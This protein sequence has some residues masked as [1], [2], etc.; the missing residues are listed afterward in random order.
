MGYGLNGIFSVP[1]M[2]P[3]ADT[4][5][6][7][8]D[9]GIWKISGSQ[10]PV[11]LYRES[12]T[13][14]V[15]AAVNVLVAGSRSGAFSEGYRSTNGGRTWIQGGLAREGIV[16]LFQSTLPA[17]GGATFM[18]DG[19]TVRFSRGAGAPGTWSPQVEVGGEPS[20]FGEVPVS[21]A[22]PNGRLLAGIKFGGTLVSDD[23]GLTFTRAVGF[24][25]PGFWPQAFTLAPDAASRYGGT[26][27]AS[28]ADFSTND[29][30]AVLASEDGGST[31]ELRYQFSPGE[32][33][34]REITDAIVVWGPD[35]VLYGGLTQTNGPNDLGTMARSL[36]GGRTWEAMAEGYAGGGVTAMIVGRDGRL[37]ASTRYGVWRTAEPLAVAGEASP[38]AS[39]RF[40]VSVRPNP[41][42]GRV[43]VVLRAAEAGTARVAV[44][45]ARGREVAVVLDGAVAAGETVRA[46]ET[47]GWPAGVYVVRASVDRETASA[48]LVVAR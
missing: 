30:A 37:Y 33:G 34:L 8:G 41:A 6:V 48:R 16:A 11:E 3:D 13:S 20:V 47:S 2:T 22:Y 46:L 4:L 12:C 10:S 15:R 7:F 14:V 38:E 5:Y 31:W 19:P 9:A 18:G 17:L 1:G 42:G 39:E 36:D 25:R 27:Y 23:G 45:D 44:V 29:R 21:E 43:E 24:S 32:L 26:L 40:G 35:G 28:M